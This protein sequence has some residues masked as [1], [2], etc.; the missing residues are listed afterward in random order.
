[1]LRRDVERL[2]GALGNLDSDL[3]VGHAVQQDREP[4]RLDDVARVD[5]RVIILISK[6]DRQHALFL[7]EDVNHR[8]FV[9]ERE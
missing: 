2:A 6:P 1:M 9:L 7:K 8:Y 5:T 4:M 3:C